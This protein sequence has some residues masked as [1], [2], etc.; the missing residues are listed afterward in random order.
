M[1]CEHGERVLQHL[2][3]LRG[4]ADAMLHQVQVV[5]RVNRRK[6]TPQQ[7]GVAVADENGFDG[8]EFFD[9]RHE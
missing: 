6:L 5:V 3:Q 4:R 1:E 7:E 2:I 9:G 8:G